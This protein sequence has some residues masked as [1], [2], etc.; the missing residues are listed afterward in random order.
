MQD[1]E[2]PQMEKRGVVVIGVTPS[3]H[4]GLPSEMIK[5]GEA[6]LKSEVCI[7]CGT[8]VSSAVCGLCWPQGA[9]NGACKK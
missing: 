1:I 7:P 5:Q 4:S 9:C 6:I 2:E 8:K 3:V